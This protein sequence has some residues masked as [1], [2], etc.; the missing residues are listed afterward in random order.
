[1]FHITIT[2]LDKPDTPLIDKDI[3]AIFG[4]ACD[5]NGVNIIGFSN[6][7]RAKAYTACAS[8]NGAV[9]K[10]IEGDLLVKL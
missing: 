8:A 9:Y 3:L 2:D 6:C 7:S 5:E 4:G 1:M 10:Y